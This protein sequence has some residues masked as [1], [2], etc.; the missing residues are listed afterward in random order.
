MAGGNAVFTEVLELQVDTASFQTD[1]NSL[2]TMYAQAMAQMT[3]AGSS[4]NG[5]VGPQVISQMAALATQLQQVGVQG[6]QALGALAQAGYQAAGQMNQVAAAVATTQ[7]AMASMIGTAQ[8]VG[9]V[10]SNAGYKAGLSWQNF[11][12]QIQRAMLRLPAMLLVAGALGAVFETVKAPIDALV[13]GFKNLEE[14][15][16]GDNMRETV[17]QLDQ[18][19]LRF[20]TIAAYPVFNFIAAQLENLKKW[21]VE[22]K[23]YVD[24]LMLSFGQFATTALK[25]VVELFSAIV[26]TDAVKDTLRLLAS[27]AVLLG[28]GLAQAVVSLTALIELVSH[29]GNAIISNPKG[30]V[31]AVAG[32]VLRGPAGMAEGVGGFLASDKTEGPSIGAIGDKWTTDSLKI[33]DDMDNALDAINGKGTQK[34]PDV[35]GKSYDSLP[36]VKAKFAEQVAAAKE[37]ATQKQDAISEQVHKGVLSHQ[38]AA[39]LIKK[40]L[41]EEKDAVDEL[42]KHYSV[43]AAAAVR[44]SGKGDLHEQASLIS[45]T[46]ASFAKVGDTIGRTVDKAGTTADNQA[47]DEV[48]AIKKANGAEDLAELKS[49]N[50]ETDEALK[51]HYKNALLTVEEYYAQKRALDKQAYDAEQA[52]IT[53]SQQGLSTTSPQY[54]T[55]ANKSRSLTSAY[56][57]TSS[58]T[59]SAEA[60]ARKKVTEEIQKA[61]DALAKQSEAEGGI[62][63]KLLESNSHRKDAL[64][65][66]ERILAAKTS[67]AQI[68]L[69]NA[70]QQMND[71]R[72]PGTAL[73]AQGQVAQQGAQ[74][75]LLAALMAQIQGARASASQSSLLPSF[76]G[77]QAGLEEARNLNTTAQNRLVGAQDKEASN[78]GSVSTAQMQALQQAAD[79]AAAALKRA[80]DAADG[81][82]SF[83]N[84][85]KDVT[86]VIGQMKGAVDDYLAGSKNGGGV[87]GGLGSAL[88]DSK[89]TGEG[90][91]LQK[92][93]DAAANSGSGILA[94]AGSAISG[95]MPLIGPAIGMMFSVI[96][97][98]F[99]SGIQ[100]MVDAINKQITDI[101]NSAAAGQIGLGQEITELQAAKQQAINELGGSKKK[102]A[103]SQLNTIL[104]SLNAQIAQLQFQQ[105]QII[106]NFDNLANAGALNTLSGTFAQWYTTWDSINQQVKQYVDA[107]GS[108]ATANEYLNQQLAVQRQTLQ[109]QLNQGDQTS[110]NDA[111]QLN[112]LLTQRVEL[113]K[114]EAQTEF[115]IVNADS[116][117][118]RTSMAVS[119]GNQLATQRYNYQQQLLQMN[120]QITLD[121]QRLTIEGQIFNVSGNLQTLWAKLNADNITSLNE[122]L[123]K[124]KDMQTILNSTAGMTFS[125]P[126]STLPTANLPI[127]GEPSVA[128]P[129]TVNVTVSSQG[130]GINTGNAGEI[131]DAIGRGIRSGRTN[132]AVPV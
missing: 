30:F 53:A 34:I 51:D 24:Q 84:A 18:M 74:S 110:L 118:R 97:D 9:M 61:S 86:Q 66:E 33:G 111:I 7:A 128:G 107:G 12:R 83:L 47:A 124:Y 40:A 78:P 73:Y 50:K 98:L 42:I 119:A 105:E 32:G 114:T 4:L 1:L 3:A 90:G 67:Q 52:D 72:L 127:P 46:D 22:N 55:L 89:V 113:M 56:N 109:D 27:S 39:P 81:M 14:S 76:S 38:D 43:L 16:L 44:G 117:E 2:V 68:D 104:E 94:A 77:A 36:D 11:G 120:E 121:Q 10:T 17:M 99:K 23:G 6:Q 126:I 102:G 82:H 132:F 101:K 70:D 116:V 69:R 92:G 79:A 106:Q 85:V 100:K 96:T 88:S 41:D 80:A 93:A 49:Q 57:S 25:S 13:E 103:Q 29:A 59:D 28:S 19:K 21:L 131:G 48:S 130:T 87:I 75:A 5:V 31:S 37:A 71:G 65:L 115:G 26:S 45:Q 129:I 60:D 112:Q 91:L 123:A 108:I 15:P 125:G 63:V 54:N 58:Q 20:E 35:P 62:S 8:A 64:A 122:Q 95:A